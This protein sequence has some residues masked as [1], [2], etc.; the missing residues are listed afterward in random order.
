MEYTQDTI[1]LLRALIAEEIPP[2]GTE[3]DTRFT[4]EVL[5]EVLKV[6]RSINEAAYI[7]WI[8]KAGK[9]IEEKEGI[10]GIK[11]GGEEI[12]YV[13]QEEYREHCLRMAEIYKEMF[14]REGGSRAFAFEPPDVLG[15]EALGGED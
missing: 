4:N 6:A 2:G 11:I 14:L 10:K 1:E 15:T 5:A 8:R 12:E 7:C 13:S 3:A 9:A